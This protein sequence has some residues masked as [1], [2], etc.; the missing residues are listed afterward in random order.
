M[1]RCRGPLLLLAVCWLATAR[2]RAD[3]GADAFF[4]KE[5]RPLLAARCVSCHGEPKVKGGLRLTSR[6]A[7]LRGGDNGPAV[8]AGNPEESLLVQAVRYQDE[9]RMPPDQKLDER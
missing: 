3:A 7:I 6:E 5:V 9:P 2:A 4:E 1:R 8:V